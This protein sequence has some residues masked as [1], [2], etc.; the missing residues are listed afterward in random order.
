MCL[1]AWAPGIRAWTGGCLSSMGRAKSAKVLLQAPLLASH[2]RQHSLA[3]LGSFMAWEPSV[4]VLLLAKATAM[5]LSV[6]HA[7]RVV[8]HQRRCALLL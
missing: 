6:A 3:F 2:H 5:V 7:Q 4:M 8:A 1:I